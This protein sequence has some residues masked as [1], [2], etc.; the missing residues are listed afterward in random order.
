MRFFGASDDEYEVE[1][2]ERLRLGLAATLILGALDSRLTR[3][4]HRHRAYLTR[5]ELM[6][7][8]RIDT[9]WQR[10]WQSQ[11]DRAFIT[12]M[13]IDVGTFRYLLESGFTRIW[14][15]TAIPRTDTDPT[16]RPRLGRRSLD[17]AGALGLYLHYLNSTMFE[18]TLQEVFALV[19]GTTN[20]YL[21]FARRALL[22]TLRSIPEGKVKF[23]EVH[24]FHELSKL[25]Q[26]RHPLLNGAFGSIDGLNIATQTS[27]DPA[28]ENA[29]YNGWLHD[30]FTSCVIVF[31][32]RVSTH[33]VAGMTRR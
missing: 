28:I 8:P 29:T 2:E 6:P 14:T 26:K 4:V 33:P 19:P 32:T 11:N 22:T 30:H 3:Q 9:P 24:E 21:K 10:L 12:T 31:S 27:D 20:R 1:E 5:P 13:G 25:I 18:K 7:D 15:T 16:G 17:A 23:P